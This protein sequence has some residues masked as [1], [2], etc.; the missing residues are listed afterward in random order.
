[1]PEARGAD[2]KLYAVVYTRDL[3]LDFKPY[4]PLID[5]VSLWVWESKDLPGL[6]RHLERCREVFPG[7]PIVLGLYLFEYPKNQFMPLNLVQ[8]EFRTA[9][10]YYRRGLIDGYQVLGSY[11]AK[12]LKTPQAGWVRDFIQHE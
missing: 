1:M 11:F 2:L 8:F 3:N 6:D 5:V 9:R 7:K 10:D 4:L 12:E